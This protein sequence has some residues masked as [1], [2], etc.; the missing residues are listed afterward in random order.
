MVSYVDQLPEELRDAEKKD[1]IA[2]Y[3]ERIHGDI[4]D[5]KV[6]YLYVSDELGFDVDVKDIEAVTD[7]PPT[8][9]F[10]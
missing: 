2:A 1:E 3:L 4:E 5:A 6:T 9:T 7:E 8:E 10:Q